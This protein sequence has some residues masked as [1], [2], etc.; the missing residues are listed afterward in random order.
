MRVVDV[1]V[2]GCFIEDLATP[3]IGD[4]VHVTLFLPHGAEVQVR[5]RVVY[6]FPAQGFAVD[7]EHDER[8]SVELEDAVFRLGR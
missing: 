1:S 5:G 4:R 7:F 3:A 8:S 2:T 6:L